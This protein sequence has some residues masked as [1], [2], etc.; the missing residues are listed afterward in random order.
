MSDEPEP[1]DELWV[2]GYGSLMW[3]PC[4]SF[5]ESAWGVVA[6]YH[7]APCI[8]SIRNRGTRETPGV[9]L[10]LER[11]GSC[12]G[13]AFR[14]EAG[15]ADA[16]REA[17]WAREMLNNVYL[18]RSL[19][20]RLDDGRRPMALT[21]VSRRDHP[22]YAGGLT[23]D[24]AAILVAQGQGHSGTALDYL[25]NVVAHLDDFGIVEGPLHRLLARAEAI[26]ART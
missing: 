23:P 24:A 13:R 20:V 6:G 18:P 8:L 14:I 21:F 7:R 11:G 25:R 22:Q 2:F 5:A 1:A 17:L 12:R 15:M 26:A 10:G 4:F 3:D 16:A 9:V 19:R